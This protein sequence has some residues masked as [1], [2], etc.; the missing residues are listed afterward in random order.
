MI[1]DLDELVL[2]CADPRSKIYIRESVQCYK[3]GAYR[4][5]IVACWV[6]VAFDLVD[7]IRELSVLGD[8]GA[9][10]EIEKLDKIREA[11][12]FPGALSFEKSLPELALNKFQFIS[13]IEKDNLTRLIDDRNRCAHPSFVSNAE[14]FEASAELAR[15][16]IYNSVK[17]ILSQPA[18]QGKYA[19]DRVLA[20]MKTNY[21]PSRP[22]Q[23]KTYLA[24]GPLAKPTKSLYSNFIT[25]LFKTILHRKEKHK[26]I[27]KSF[28][29]LDSVRIMHPSLWQE[30]FPE[31][32]NKSLAS[33]I[34]EGELL[35]GATF[36]TRP[37][38][39]EC[40]EFISAVNLLKLSGL[41]RNFPVERL[42]DIDNFLD[43]HVPDKLKKPAVTRIKQL[44]FEE[45]EAIDWVILMPVEVS[46]RLLKLYSASNSF[47]KA[48]TIGRFLASRIPEIV[49]IRDVLDEV[50]SIALKNQQVKGSNGLV[51]LLH[52]IAADNEVGIDYLKNK[53]TERKLKIENI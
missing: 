11:N 31:V 53:L 33:T 47:E 42:P 22:D 15:L 30:K 28:F 18:V 49:K 1:A 35:N 34:D 6:A 37:Q 27:Q 46:E 3:S 25:V 38:F 32:L 52:A 14:V 24:E 41:I 45:I 4:A 8:P 50:I 10:A 13:P 36:F 9:K 16:H 40:F 17:S 23:I 48:N 26:L 39:S 12:N 20:E 2:T 44:T 21:F 19:L 29:S 7:K 43:P 5:S 51:R